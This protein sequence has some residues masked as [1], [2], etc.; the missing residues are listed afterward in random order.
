MIRFVLADTEELHEQ[1][2]RPRYYNTVPQLTP[3]LQIAIMS[4]RIRLLEDALAQSHSLTSS[5]QHPLLNDE[6]KNIKFGAD[7]ARPIS[8]PRTPRK[9]QAPDMVAETI[10]ALGTL[11]IGDNGASKYFGRAAGTEVCILLLFPVI[12]RY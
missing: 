5:E 6:L 8:Q 9:A 4:Q 7:A 3:G 12:Q 11:A 10:T 2:S 1:V